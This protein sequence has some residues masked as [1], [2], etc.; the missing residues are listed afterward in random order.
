LWAEIK[1]NAPRAFAP[2][3]TLEQAQNVLPADTLYI[4]FSV[5]AV[6]TNLFL[7]NQGE[8]P[9]KSLCVHSTA[10]TQKQLEALVDGLRAQI[11]NPKDLTKAVQ[12]SRR[13]FEKLFPEEARKKIGAA[14]RLLISPD[15][16]LWDVPFA[17]LV[18]NIAAAPK[19]LGEE[20]AITY[21]QS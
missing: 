13:L 18:T 4:A 14:K 5:G 7:L 8:E 11:A 16:P 6:Q 3:L 10:V 21:T 17:A 1:R 2:S 20:R 15:G 12:A 9:E 19:Y